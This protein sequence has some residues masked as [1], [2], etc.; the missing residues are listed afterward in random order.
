MAIKGRFR[1]AWM[2]RERCI[3]GHPFDHVDKLTGWRSCRICKAAA[4][5]KYQARK[6]AALGSAL[7]V[8][9]VSAG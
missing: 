8:L 6:R 1:N 7:N 5:R 2:G 3:N 9:G 4:T